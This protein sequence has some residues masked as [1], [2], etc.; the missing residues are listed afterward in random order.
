MNV[1]TDP[2][3]P[4]SRPLVAGLRNAGLNTV[5]VYLEAYDTTPTG[6]NVDKADA[7]VNWTQ[8]A[9]MYLIL[10]IGGGPMTS[11]KGAGYF[12]PAKV[13][14]FWTYYAPRYANR[15]HVIYEIENDP[16][17]RCDKPWLSESIEMERSAYKTIRAHAP[18][19]HIVLFSFSYIPH[20][21]CTRAADLSRVDEVVNWSNASVGMHAADGCSMSVATALA[22]TLSFARNQQ[23][24]TLITEVIDG[25]TLALVPTLE[26]NTIGWMDFRWLVNNKDPGGL[27][28]GA[29]IGDLVSRLRA[30]LELGH[31][32]NAVSRFI[33]VVGAR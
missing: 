30:L 20:T 24:P 22:S 33:V 13:S 14:D 16:D 18:D 7:L 4:L 28:E 12:V 25:S 3:F 31:V 26:K 17:Y 29:C 19:T 10:A 32:Q 11:D 27:Q 9:G 6:K 5:H 23:V 21:R 2:N 8:A 1:D 15:T